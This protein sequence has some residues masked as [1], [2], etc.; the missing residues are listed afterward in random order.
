MAGQMGLPLDWPASPDDDAFIVSESNRLAVRHLDHWSLW[1]VAITLL[2][3]PRKSGRSTLGR[4]FTAKGA[5]TLIDDADRAEEEML[6]HAW[7]AAQSA[8]RPLLLIA[9]APPPHWNIRLPDLRSRMVATPKITLG[10][11][12]DSLIEALIERHYARRGLVFPAKGLAFM[13]RRLERSH[14]ALDRALDAIDTAAF[15]RQHRITLA[16]VRE[17]LVSSHLIDAAR[18]LR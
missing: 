5:G 3:G 12:N 8:R 10:E 4:I 9:D 13:L 1:P 17:A 2:T 6:F 7:N 14:V 11:P 18:D 15:S 16:L